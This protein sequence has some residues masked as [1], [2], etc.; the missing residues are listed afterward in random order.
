[1]YFNKYTSLCLF[2]FQH[3]SRKL[4]QKIVYLICVSKESWLFCLSE[5][6]ESHN[7][8]DDSSDSDGDEPSLSQEPKA[9]RNPSTGGGSQPGST[10]HRPRGAQLTLTVEA[11]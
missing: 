9:P 5:G 6:G 1:M 10:V 7:G 2:F 11:L 4:T 3:L 8:D